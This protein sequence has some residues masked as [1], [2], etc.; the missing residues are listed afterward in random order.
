MSASDTKQP[1]DDLAYLSA[2]ARSGEDA[3]LLGGRFLVWWAGL[4]SLV[5]LTHWAIVM[6]YAP[7]G[8]EALWPLWIGYIV[9]ASVGSVLLGA[10]IRNKPGLGAAANR[11]ES[12]VWQSAG[13]GIGVIFL[14][15]AAGV[16]SGMLPTV[17]FNVLLPVALSA[18][19][20]A[21]MTVARVSRQ[22]GLYT[23]A[24]LAFFGA[25]AGI[26]FAAGHW[27]YPI[28]ALALLGSSVMPGLVL[29]RREPRS[30]A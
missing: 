1:G 25:G 23:P 2:L 24:V 11:T 12:A 14:G 26:A 30:L 8:A 21:W 28:T 13:A 6:G 19:G 10:T 22:S 29:L 20:V 17:F 18:Y 7:F 15:V 27:V 4:T 3:P 16:Q 9:I 5:I